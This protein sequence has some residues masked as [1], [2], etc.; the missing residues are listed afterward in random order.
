MTPAFNHLSPGTVEKLQKSLHE[1]A[2]LEPSYRFYSLYDKVWCQDLLAQAYRICKTIQSSPEIDRKTIE[3]IEAEG[4][5][6][7]L[8]NLSE[9]LRMKTFQTQPLRRVWIPKAVE[10]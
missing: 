7:W 10:Q 2:K 5:D 4:L 8:G 9:E 6:K 1:K 3:A